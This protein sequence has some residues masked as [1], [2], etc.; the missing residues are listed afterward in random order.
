[1]QKLLLTIALLTGIHAT[2][3]A[4]RSNISL[5]LKAG[6]TLSNF[7]GPDAGSTN[8]LFGLQAGGFANISLSDLVAFQPELLYSQRGAVV[9]DRSTEFT[10]RFHYIDGPL[11]FHVNTGGL[12]FE[13]GPQLGFLV[14]A[15]DKAGGTTTVLPENTFYTVDASY[16]AG[17]GYQRKSG[18]GTGLRVNGGINNFHK[19]VAVGATSVQTRARHLAFQLYLTYSVNSR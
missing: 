1:M 9:P 11:L 17:L 14:K 19:P 13:A 3:H 10:R 16:V 2:A 15:Q 8:R 6:A 7:I 5:G 12:F 4:Q 18:L